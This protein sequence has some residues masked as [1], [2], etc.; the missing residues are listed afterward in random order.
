MR[1]RQRLPKER[2]MK[3]SKLG[4]T[5]GKKFRI[6]PPARRIH[7]TCGELPPIQDWWS[8]IASPEGGM[9]LLNPRSEHR[10]L[11]GKDHVREYRTDPNGS[12]GLLVLKSQV[13]LR[14]TA[15]DVEPL[16]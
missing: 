16:A 8:V 12:D 13:I 9:L 7:P 2:T 3:K 11:L 15:T 4:I 14:G 10:L 5:L 1:G 6:W